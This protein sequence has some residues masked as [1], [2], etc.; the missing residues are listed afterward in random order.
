MSAWH[1]MT[2]HV[3][4]WEYKDLFVAAFYKDEPNEVA[5]MRCIC[6]EHGALFPKDDGML[7]IIEHGWIPFAWREDDTPARDEK[8]FP[9]LWT[10]YLTAAQT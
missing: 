6:A 4:P 2:E 1:S 7:S 9:P 3:F 10:D 5:V 8:K